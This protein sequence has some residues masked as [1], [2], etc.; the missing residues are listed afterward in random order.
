MKKLLCF[1]CALMLCLSTAGCKS[2]EG[3]SGG[4]IIRSDPGTPHVHTYT[5]VKGVKAT[6]TEDGNSAYYTCDCGKIFLKKGI[7]YVETS[8][9]DVT[10]KAKGHSFDRKIHSDEYLISEATENEPQIFAASCKN[11]GAKSS[12]ASATFTYGKTLTEYYAVQKELYAPN[13]LTLSLYDAENCIYGFTWNTQTE[14]AR[15]V[16]K[17]KE[18]DGSEE[19]FVRANF[20]EAKSYQ[21][22]AGSDISI[23]YYSC[24]AEIALTP[25]TEYIYSVGDKYMETYTESANVRAV[26]PNTSDSWK[27]VHVSDSQAEGNKE[28]G[29]QGTGTAFSNVLKNVCASSDIKFMV[30]TGDVV[31]YSKYQSYWDYMLNPNFR[32]LSAMP[33]MAI[34]GNHETTYKQGSNE[35]FNRFNYKIPTQQTDLGFYY[36]FSYGNVKFIMVNTNRLSNNCLTSD[37][38][39]WLEYELKNKTEKWTIVSMHNPMY[40]V[41]K[42]GSDTTKN[43]TTRALAGQLTGLFARYGVDMVLQGHDHMVSRTHPINEKG[44][45]TAEIVESLNNVNYIKN[46][47]GTIY[48]MSGPAGDQAKT[49]SSIFPHDESLYAYA[50]PSSISSWAEIEVAGNR[51]TV[52][53]K[54]AKSETAID[55]LTWGI[56]KE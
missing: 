26:N 36:S 33:V 35:T 31:E 46:P 8:L 55:L 22:K 9:K 53:V 14:P 52:T 28:N 37:Q 41:G 45:A 27:F 16:V 49:E 24:K 1:L 30:H 15:P 40:S 54:T 19:R 44:D 12:D 42:W 7:E 32:Y 48:T 17:I 56:V 38:Y 20:T 11:C 10:L 51:L 34:S 21:R 50:L 18:K 23:T 29:G 5:L 13:A 25:N 2:G 6:C 47:N 39:S 4:D 43:A 3:G